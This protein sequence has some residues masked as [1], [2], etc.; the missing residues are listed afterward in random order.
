MRISCTSVLNKS[1]TKYLQ[2]YA[3]PES[4]CFR[5]NELNNYDALLVIP[6]Y[7]ETPDFLIRLQQQTFAGIRRLLLILVSNHP[8]GLSGSAQQAAHKSHDN[9]INRLP[10]EL[11]KEKNLS[12]FPGTNLDVLL[13]NR[14]AQHQISKKQGVGLARKIGADIALSLIAKKKSHTHWIFN[15]DAD[16]H[17]PTDYFEAA[18]VDD[19]GIAALLYPF[20]HIGLDDNVLNATKLYEKRLEG[21]VKGL[22][23]AG[24]PYAFHTLGSTLCISADAYAKA[25][26]FPK[27]PAGEDFYLLSKVAKLGTIHSLTVPVIQIE[28]RCSTRIP[29]GTGPAVMSLMESKDLLDEEIF[30][31]PELFTALGEFIDALE[32]RVTKSTLGKLPI[33]LQQAA[34]H[35]NIDSLFAHIA[36]QHVSEERYLENVHIWFDGFRTLKFVHFLR[37]NYYP[38]LKLSSTT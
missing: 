7:M 20:T 14:I 3:E 12:F 19:L 28:A 9:L 30:Y 35:I 11:W 15:T 27:R 16:A 26:G 21:Y 4:K 8:S 34:N 10:A 18:K 25:R 23:A 36:S 1:T 37:D 17:L 2:N 24:S 29:F 38:N 22:K 6:A 13:V 31:H 5:L 32:S 33:E